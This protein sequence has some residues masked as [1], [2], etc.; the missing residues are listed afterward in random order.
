M[1]DDELCYL[2]YGLDRLNSKRTHPQIQ[3][4]VDDSESVIELHAPPDLQHR[5]RFLPREVKPNNWCFIITVDY[6][7][8][9]AAIVE[10]RRTEADWP[11]IHF[12]WRLSPIFN[13]LSSQLLSL[14]G[15]QTVPV[16]AGIDGLEQDETAFLFS[17]MIPNEKGQSLKNEWICIL[18]HN[19][20]IS[21]QCSFQEI[22]Q[23]IK[24]G[25]EQSANHPGSE[26]NIDRLQ[27]LVPVAAEVA[28][29]HFRNLRNLFEQ[30][31]KSR[32]EELNENLTADLHKRLVAYQEER[33]ISK[34]L[35]EIASGE[36]KRK[37]E[38]TQRTFDDSI[39]WLE[40]ALTPAQNSW[41]QLVCVFTAGH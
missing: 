14:Y 7:R 13:W 8:M 21:G 39:N 25:M 6:S 23:R 20:I 10:S 36:Y 29:K 26:F 27:G 9:R 19:D 2:T 4:E 28:K 12:L 3:F 38:E 35:K 22:R 31:Q 5:F 34:K 18:F 24:L 33:E 40:K 30:E 1:F 41:V 17:G 15:R 32:L 11:E 37:C 16:L